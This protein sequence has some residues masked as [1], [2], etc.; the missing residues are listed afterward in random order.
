MNP[1]TS[2]PLSF[3]PGENATACIIC[4]C[5][6]LAGEYESVAATRFRRWVATVLPWISARALISHMASKPRGPTTFANC[7]APTW[8]L[9]ALPPEDLVSRRVWLRETTEDLRP[10]QRLGADMGGWSWGSQNPSPPLE[11]CTTIL[12][13]NE[14][15]TAYNTR[16]VPRPWIKGVLI[17][18]LN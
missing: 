12:F 2:E 10:R 7:G 13:T 17:N 15:R 6:V 14:R 5:I 8:S 16:P 11:F 1:R 3:S 9:S 18:L 4:G